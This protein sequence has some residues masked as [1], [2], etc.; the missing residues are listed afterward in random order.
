MKTKNSWIYIVGAIVLILLM[1]WLAYKS[2]QNYK[3]IV[4]QQKR[5]EVITSLKDDYR[6]EMG[7][8]KAHADSLQAALDECCPKPKTL[9]PEEEIA[10]LKK[11]V[12]KLK[13]KV[14]CPEKKTSLED[15]PEKPFNNNFMPPPPPDKNS[16][17]N[18]ENIPGNGGTLSTTLF[19]GGLEG[20]WCTTIDANGHI[21]YAMKNSVF[22][23]GK[24]TI[25][26]PKLN[27]E[28]GPDMVLDASTGW[29]YYADGRLVSVQEINNYQYAV[30]WNV[31]IGQTNYGSG[32]YA[33]YLP[34]QLMK[35]L[36]NKSRGKEWGEITD[37]DLGKMRAEN[38]NVWTPN[39]EGTLRPFRL[40]AENGRAI[41]KE[42][43]NMYQGWNFRT[44]IYAQKKTTTTTN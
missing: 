23:A 18:V 6:N 8:A 37:E 21:L 1:A 27:G 33:T 19:E 43:R 11:E 10:L 16:N 28:N 31:Y 17:R 2:F 4:N 25:S 15:V 29:W 22:Q 32:S 40:D 39:A 13:K 3:T 34:H 24:P 20:D 7:V 5:I 36:I 30:E 26:A 41:G 35:P 42:D 38:S 44:R 9:T 12:E 14:P